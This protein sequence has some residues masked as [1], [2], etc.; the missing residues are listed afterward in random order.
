MKI[1]ASPVQTV[2]TTNQP[3]TDGLK[4]ERRLD[5]QALESGDKQME[6]SSHTQE[7]AARMAKLRRQQVNGLVMKLSRLII[8]ESHPSTHPLVSF[9]K[10][11]LARRSAELEGKVHCELN[12]S[13]ADKG[14][15]SKF[16]CAYGLHG[17]E[18]PDKTALTDEEIK[19]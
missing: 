2:L 17:S 13:A 1:R 16:R 14:R 15:K 10:Q 4:A 3:M 12:S 18:V 9:S 6:S 5:K 11:M 19:G 8:V 7:R